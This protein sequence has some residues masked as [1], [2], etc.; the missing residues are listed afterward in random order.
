LVG[1]LPDQAV[2]DYLIKGNGVGKVVL[3]SDISEIKLLLAPK[4]NMIKRRIM[5]ENEFV[6]IY[7][8]ENQNRKPLFYIYE[9]DGKIWGIQI[10]DELFRTERGVGIGSSLGAMRIYY[11]QLNIFAIPRKVTCLWIDQE[12]LK[13]IKFIIADDTRID[14]KTERFPFDI[15]IN[16]ILIGKSPY[17]N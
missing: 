3:D 6:I 14:F 9:R 16:S 2:D 4:Y 13:E 11:T 15:K 5:V 7:K 12:N 1:D 8:I 17:L 10:V